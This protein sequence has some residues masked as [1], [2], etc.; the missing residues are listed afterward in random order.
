MNGHCKSCG[1]IRSRGNQKVKE[2]LQEIKV[3]FK[4]EYFVYINNIRLERDEM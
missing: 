2:I 4:P 1:C 3:N